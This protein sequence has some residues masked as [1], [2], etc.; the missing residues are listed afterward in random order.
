[1]ERTG[2]Q[3][4]LAQRLAIQSGIALHR[5]NPD[6]MA[7]VAFQIANDYL[8]L[9][10]LQERFD[11]DPSVSRGQAR[12]W[13]LTAYDHLEG[14]PLIKAMYQLLALGVSDDDPKASYEYLKQLD[15]IHRKSAGDDRAF[16]ERYLN[17]AKSMWSDRDYLQAA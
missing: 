17:R 14:P 13:L 16:A 4:M 9:A 2:D 8:R 3:A 5:S 10:V 11:G 6:R 7:R 12:Q 1:H 15:A